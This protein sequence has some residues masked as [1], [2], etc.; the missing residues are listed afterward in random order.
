MSE[1]QAWPGDDGTSSFAEAEAI[2]LLV[3]ADDV[4]EDGQYERSSLGHASVWAT[5]ALVRATRERGLRPDVK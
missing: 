4:I 2:N 3:C 1:R 5:I